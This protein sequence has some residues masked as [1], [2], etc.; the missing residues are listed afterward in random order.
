M[1][2]CRRGTRRVHVRCTRVTDGAPPEPG[3]ASYPY[4]VGGWASMS[5][6]RRQASSHSRRGRL[7][8]AAPLV[9]ALEG[10]AL[11]SLPGAGSPFLATVPIETVSPG[12]APAGSA[13]PAGL[14]PAQVRQAY[15]FD[16]IRFGGGLVGDGT[17]Q[18]IAI[19]DAYNQP[20]IKSDLHAFDQ[21]FGL[22]DPP[23]FQVVAQDGSQNPPANSPKGDWGYE[24]SLDVEWAHA[25]AP[26]AKILLVE[27]ASAGDDLETAVRWAAAQP[28]VSVV[29]M[30]WGSPEYA[31]EYLDDYVYS[32]PA[33][34]QGVTFL[35]ATGD[36]GS[37]GDYPAASPNVLAV[38]GTQFTAALDA[39]GDYAAET[40]WNSGGGGVSPY[41]LQPGYQKGVVTQ[42]ATYRATPDVAMDSGTGVAVY[43]SYDAS[44]DWIDVGGTSLAT[45]CWGALVAIA[46]QGLAALGLGTLGN[47]AAATALYALDQKAGPI[48]FHDVT[49]GSNGKPA[50][51]GYDL[52][53]GLGTP[54]AAA[55]AAGLSGNIPAPTPVGPTGSVAA[56]PSFH[57]STVAGATAYHLVAYDQATSGKVLD[58]VVTG[59]TSYTPGPGIFAPGRAYSWQV[60]SLTGLSSAGQASTPLGF[61]LPTAGVP[62]PTS[63]SNN[64]TVSPSEPTLTWSAV[65]GASAY[66]VTIVDAANPGTAIVQQAIVTGTS[67]TP[68][69]PLPY[70]HTFLW[71]VQVQTAPGSYGVASAF[72]AFR[73]APLSAPGPSGPASGAILTTATPTIQWSA[74]PGAVSYTLTLTDVTAGTAP[75]TIVGISGTSYAPPTAL[76]NGDSYRWTVAAVDAWGDAGTASANQ[77]FNI[78]LPPAPVTTPSPASPNGTVATTLPALRWTPVAGATSYGISIVDQTGGV[79]T[80][81]VP[82]A[83]VAGTSY[84]P[85]AP[86]LVGHTYSWQVLAYNAAGAPSGWSAALQFTVKDEP[87]ADFDGTGR[88]E[89]ALYT[90]QIGLWTI[91]N[92]ASWSVTYAWAGQAAGQTVPAPGDYDGIGRAEMAYYTPATGTWTIPNPLTGTSRTVVF[93]TP[94][95]KVIPVAGDYD[96]I[97]RTEMAFFTPAT[98]VWTI[99]NPVT[100]T[101]RSVSWGGA[102]FW[103]IPIPGDYDGIGR[104]ELAVYIPGSATWYIWNPQ[105]NLVRSFNWG[106]TNYWS[107]P[108][109]GDYDGIGHTEPAIFLPSSATWIVL[110]PLT[111]AARTFR[112]GAANLHDV[113]LEAPVGSLGAVGLLGSWTSTAAKSAAVTTALVPAGPAAV[114]KPTDPP[115]PVASTVKAGAVA[116]WKTVGQT[117][118]RPAWFVD[119]LS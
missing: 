104:T 106:G 2:A 7:R 111:V 88:S 75:V 32:T 114:A 59:A 39:Q 41:E 61:A 90:P 56:A 76:T 101:A 92:P 95:Q 37:P 30:S 13:A 43:D 91:V 52:V 116:S 19:V 63:P 54:Q 14:S 33:G 102:N 51:P 50:G 40:G 94:G 27:A 1:N 31:Y 11:L 70:G 45:P 85:A 80:S 18:T 20:N 47:Q 72:W 109:P 119:G 99:L 12:A 22:P 6:T 5:G 98:G 25:L 81:V 64:S 96:G 97:G 15:G 112:A 115:P 103:S 21:Q 4:A 105:T 78:N 62:N 74:V 117:V 29:S 35:A 26:G 24:I 108:V 87:A 113:P 3:A 49:T 86:L 69:S 118:A 42:S 23:S 93:G 16:A 55:I 34:H 58:V 83:K 48:S 84:V 67:F 60:A 68:T 46:D 65:A 79:H 73:V 57:W 8:R 82:L 53:T 77:T 44:W 9:E 107:V 10:R 110:N 71:S 89:I 100:N 36:T 28:G 66:A 17:G 38:G